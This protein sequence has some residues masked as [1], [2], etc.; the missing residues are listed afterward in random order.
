MNGFNGSNSSSG[1]GSMNGMSS[2]DGSRIGN[3]GSNG[4]SG[5]F[6]IPEAASRLGVPERSLRQWVREGRVPIIPPLIGQRGARIAAST[7]ETL[8]AAGAAGDGGNTGMSGKSGSSTDGNTG[9]IG[10]DGGTGSKSSS[11]NGGTGTTAQDESETLHSVRQALRLHARMRREESRRYQEELA[12]R[13]TE[14]TFL[15]ERLIAAERE[16]QETRL[17]MAQSVQAQQ[18]TARELEALREERAALMAPKKVRWWVRLWG[19]G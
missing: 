11:G 6:T 16:G 18:A 19:R 2:T 17:L 3:S 14:L 1:T 7:V 12:H 5:G 8:L 4:S 13:D 9:A 10:M 15:K